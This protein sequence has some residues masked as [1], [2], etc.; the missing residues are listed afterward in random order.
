MS[1]DLTVTFD[2]RYV[3]GPPGDRVAAAQANA[4]YALLE[5]LLGVVG[6]GGRVPLAFALKASSPTDL[7]AQRMLDRLTELGFSTVPVE[8][9]EEW[10]DATNAKLVEGL[11]RTNPCPSRTCC[12]PRWSMT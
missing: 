1:G 10:F 4:I 2:I 6:P 5:G 7:S 3:S 8:P 9:P 12:W 11:A